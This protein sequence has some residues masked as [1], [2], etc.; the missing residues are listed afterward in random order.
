MFNHVFGRVNSPQ[1]QTVKSVPKMSS[2]LDMRRHIDETRQVASS[3]WQAVCGIVLI[4]RKPTCPHVH[5]HINTYTYTCTC[6]HVVCS[7]YWFY[8]SLW[9]TTTCMLAA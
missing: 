8:P 5:I 1:M 7:F 6:I 9:V 2:E 4:N 3:K